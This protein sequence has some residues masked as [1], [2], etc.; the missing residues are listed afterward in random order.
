MLEAYPALSLLPPIVA[1]VLVIV[2]KKVL[3]S[4]GVGVVASALLI[5]DFNIAKT[6]LLLWNTL[7]DIFWDWEAGTANWYSVLILLFLLTLGVITSM[8]MMAGGTSAFAEWMMT[9]IKSRRGAQFLAAGLGMAIFIDDYFNA[10]AVGQVSRPIT[11]RHHVSRAKL[12][13]L[14]DSTSAPVSVLTPFSSWGASIIGIMA[15]LLAVSTVNVDDVS[16][17]MYSAVMNYYAI[18]ALVLLWMVI[19]WDADFGPMRREENRAINEGAPFD[20]ATP[21]PGQLTEDLP[22][23]EPGARRSL[24][25]PFLVLVAGVIVGILFTG[26]V[27]GG[28]ANP[29]EMLAN[30]DVPA[31]LNYGGIAGLLAAMYYYLRYTRPNPRFTAGVFFRGLVGGAR[32]MMPAINILVFAWMLGALISSMGTGDYIGSLVAQT[33]VPSQWL[34]PILFLVAAC[35][36]FATGTSWG[37]FGIL[38][39]L[40]AQILG[41]L[42]GGDDVLLA[43][44]GAVLA[45]AVFGDHCSPISDTTILSSTGAS[46]HLMTHV[47]TQLPYAFLGAAASLVGYVVF[48]LTLSAAAG[49]VAMLVVL[50]A[51]IFLRRLGNVK[52][53]SAVR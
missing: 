52:A 18:G 47:N 34:V 33:Q 40:G 3:V 26:Y 1:I 37:S 42:P 51:A 14:I 35:M 50:V 10:L 15:P 24:I 41:A 31:A 46:C 11:D 38:L 7:S 28:S 25:V 22:R 23:H 32:S 44:F 9:R 19:A 20:P 45:G 36:A 43:T 30:T 4:L 29:M 17:F 8:V 6:L 16:A 13:Y 39:P 49:L 27:A 21:I 53:S 12:A 2:T 48:A 5:S